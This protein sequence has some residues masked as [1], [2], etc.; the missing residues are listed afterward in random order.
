[1]I[2]R[3]SALLLILAGSMVA[4]VAAQ[5]KDI[6]NSEIRDAILSLVHSYSLLDNK[7]ERHEQRERALGELV[8]KGLL[9]LQKNQRMFE[10]M[11]GL[12][13]RLED[14]VGQIETRMIDQEEKI[15]DV[16]T[17]ILA[18]M[19]DTRG[20]S[21]SRG[22]EE[23]GEIEDAGLTKKLDILNENVKGLRIQIGELR[24][25][26]SFAE[27]N[28]KELLQKAE[29]LVETRLASADEVINKL[30][31]KLSNF[32]VVTNGNGNGNGNSNGYANSHDLGERLENTLAGIAETLQ[33]LPDREFVQGLTNET[34]ESITDMRLEVLTASDKSFTKTGNRMKEAFGNLDQQV[35]EILRFVSEAN[36]AQES[37]YEFSQKS[38]NELKEEIGNLSKIERVLVTTGD[39]I[40]DLKR[41]V[42]YGIHQ[43]LLE[44]NDL[45][46]E[47]T[48]GIN[49]SFNKRLDELDGTMMANISAKIETEISQVWRQIGI[50]YQEISS[51][52]QALDKL[53][54]QTEVY[55]N[56]TIN[57]M[58]SMQGKMTLVT[59]RMA[60]VD[61]NL[62]YLLGRLSLVTQE[63][64]Q[65]K[66]GLS[67]ALESIRNS[68]KAVQEQVQD[69]GPGPH[70]IPDPEE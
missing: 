54:Q 41:R 25:E 66:T 27:E 20:G 16:L 58:D 24:A 2:T 35:S 67:G 61:E 60:E 36:V 1:M 38:T 6:T 44:V 31:D 68:F 48:T 5:A 18:F 51:S 19:K 8:K 37:F 4:N 32:Y 42:E 34:L 9:T 21:S 52:K 28:N 62:N 47:S 3:A 40:L 23:S 55:V 65:I 46:K 69:S 7:L 39:N 33:K 22:A 49:G 13:Q 14:R 45:V 59:G 10:P 63:F 56:G 64:G 70:N 12:I 57:T 26:R 17:D 15:K 29:R 11:K 50:M 30:E 43:I 53:Q